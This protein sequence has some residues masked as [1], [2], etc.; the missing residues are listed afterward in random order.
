MLLTI[1]IPTYNRPDKILKRVTE[2]IPLLRDEVELLIIDNASKENVEHLILKEAPETIGR[3]R[4]IR[5]KVN[6]GGNAN[7]C[8]CFEEASGEWMWLLGDDDEIVDTALSSILSEIEQLSSQSQAFAGLNFSTT[9][10]EYPNRVEINSKES[11]WKSIN[12]VREFSN[13]LFISS[14]VY[15]LTQVRQYIKDGYHYCFTCAPQ[16]VITTCAISSGLKWINSPRHV[17]RW[18]E[19]ERTD[20]WN[21]YPVLSGLQSLVELPGC[22]A[23]VIEHIGN[24]LESLLWRNFLLGGLNLIFTDNTKGNKYWLLQFQKLRIFLKGKTKIKAMILSMAANICYYFPI[25]R[26]LGEFIFTTLRSHRPNT[27]SSLQRL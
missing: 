11:Y 20:T 2:L 4:H 12:G 18:C 8:R 5:N 6:I 10:Y 23:L 3:I 27:E 25:F 17:V 14:C 1:A 16:M 19:P 7:I 24:T 15:N 22:S 26:K 21:T 13:A 9:I